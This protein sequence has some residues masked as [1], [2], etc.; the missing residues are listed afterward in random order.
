MVKII[1][2][3]LLTIPIMIA[4]IMTFLNT[5][6]P[7]YLSI[8]LTDNFT[9]VTADVTLSVLFIRKLLEHRQSDTLIGLIRE[10]KL[11]WLQL[12]GS[13]AVCFAAWIIR[14]VSALVPTL[15]TVFPY[16][17]YLYPLLTLQMF[18]NY[19]LSTAKITKEILKSEFKA[20]GV[21]SKSDAKS[22]NPS[23]RTMFDI[24]DQVCTCFM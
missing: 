18:S 23:G 14:L 12:A 21:N 4:T 24:S 8:Y 3:T 11:E 13:L 17:S 22:K 9:S 6:I 20:D 15:N 7:G 16:V 10:N 2:A 5:L 19:L 1:F